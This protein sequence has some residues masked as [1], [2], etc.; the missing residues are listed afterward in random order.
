MITNNPQQ[1][2][3]KKIAD[4]AAKNQ[5]A[6]EQISNALK[7]PSS[8]ETPKE[9][10][11]GKNFLVGLLTYLGGALIVAGYFIYV[12]IVWD[13]IGSLPRV[14]L[15]LGISLGAFVIA[16]ALH[17][18]TKYAKAATPV[19]IFAC[20]S[21]PGGLFILL[22]EYGS[23]DDAL[24]ASVIVFGIMALQCALSFITIRRSP[25]LFFTLFYAMGWYGCTLEYLHIN[26]P[27]LWIASGL[28]YLYLAWRIQSTSYRSVSPVT[29]VAG[30]LMALSGCY[31]YLGNTDADILMVTLIL[32]LMVWAMY[33]GSRTLVIASLVFLIDLTG[34]YFMYSTDAYEALVYNY[35]ALG[36]SISL[37]LTG[38]WI[39][40]HF[41]GI[42]SP[43]W[44]FFGSALMYCSAFTIVYETAWDIVFPALPAF[45]LY[46][47]L[48]LKNRTLLVTAILALLGFISYY[49]AEYFSDTVG[50]PLVLMGMGVLVIVAGIV[51]YKTSA[52]MADTA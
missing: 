5:L 45:M 16:V 33:I 6:I 27:M 18:D 15:T 31:Y 52:K 4:I 19:F 29:Y 7:N 17:K 47:S 48:Q 50:W 25:L 8:L 22:K 26:E 24:L 28:T 41:T 11:K 40:R 44:Y 51:T 36:A 12:S 10:G 13:D 43:V 20:L 42:L 37:L 14:I 21:E 39:R 38:Y 34:K 9:T 49:T 23:G 46:V 1:K 3:L 2:A 30:A 35:T 32:S